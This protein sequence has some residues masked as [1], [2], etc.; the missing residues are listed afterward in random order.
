MRNVISELLYPLNEPLK[1]K[2][3]LEIRNVLH[4]NHVRIAF[5]RKTFEVLEQIPAPI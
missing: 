4:R 1:D 3:A 5:L 2:F